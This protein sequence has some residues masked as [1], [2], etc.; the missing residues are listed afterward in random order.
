M[1]KYIFYIDSPYVG[2]D[3]EEE[4]ELITEGMI[5]EEEEREVQREFEMFVNEYAGWRKADK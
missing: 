5:P 1:A 3:V 4:V 2:A